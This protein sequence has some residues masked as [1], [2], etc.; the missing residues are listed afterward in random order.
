M[1]IVYCQMLRYLIVVIL[2]F[3]LINPG[4][5]PLPM[6]PMTS[7]AYQAGRAP[8]G[9]PPTGPPP[10]MKA[11]PPPPPPSAHPMSN[12]SSLPPKADGELIALQSRHLQ[13]QNGWTHF[14]LQ[15]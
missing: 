9:P 8:Y 11:T 3:P 5:A 1:L 12:A 14:W 15:K 6:N 7:H 4:S 2:D 13:P 10:A